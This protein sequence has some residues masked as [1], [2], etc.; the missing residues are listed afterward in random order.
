MAS[1]LPLVFNCDEV[2]V[3][4]ICSDVSLDVGITSTIDGIGSIA[5]DSAVTYVFLNLFI[6]ACLFTSRENLC[7]IYFTEKLL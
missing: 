6:N 2:K 1:V 3:L 5:L 4:I 7:C